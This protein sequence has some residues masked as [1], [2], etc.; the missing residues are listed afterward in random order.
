MNRTQNTLMKTGK[1]SV[2]ML[3]LLLIGAAVH[4]APPAPL[5]V[6]VYDFTDTDKNAGDY[7]AKVTTLVNAGLTGEP[8]LA[9]LERA[10]LNKALNEQAFDT[11][12][13][14]SSDAAAKI[15]QITGAK[16]LV[17]GQVLKISADHIV[18]VADVIGTETARL[19]AIKVEG[20]PDNLVELTTKLAGNIAQTIKAQA[21][22]LV[23]A[24]EETRAERLDRVI[25]GLK[26][27][28]LPAVS[29]S[30]VF[31]RPDAKSHSPASEDEFGAIRLKAGF[32]V[33]DENSD[34][35]PDVEITGVAN[36]DVGTKQGNMF[37][38]GGETEL[39]VQDRRTGRIIAFDRQESK[40]T[41]P[42]RRA[43]NRQAQA[44]A[45]DDLAARI[46]PLL[47]Q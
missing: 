20:N 36:F 7:G 17:A 44:N 43:A 45:V 19:Y 26:G 22:N 29:V 33:V 27:K 8:N 15:G 28:K 9:L 4:A 2:L 47:A 35:K 6:A 40:V 1:L 21:A 25:L 37:L 31:L 11:S 14:V 34:Q 16:V 42:S 30:I 18:I 23:A 3:S 41:D 13:M 5:T 38:V 39:K 10:E 12:G 46:L 32:T 24:T